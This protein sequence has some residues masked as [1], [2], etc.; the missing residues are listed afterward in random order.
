MVLGYCWGICFCG[1]VWV[2]VGGNGSEKGCRVVWLVVYGCGLCVVSSCFEGIVCFD[3]GVV[4]S[5]KD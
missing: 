4:G 2:G 1:C 5:E 3:S